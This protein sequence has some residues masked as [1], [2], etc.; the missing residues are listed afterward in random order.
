AMYQ[1]RR[2]G[3]DSDTFGWALERAL[4][5]FVAEAWRHPDEGIWEVRGQRQ[6]FTHSKV[7]AWVAVDRAV[8]SAEQYQLDAPVEEWKRLRQEIH[9]EVC[10]AGYNTEMNSFVQYYGSNELDASLLMIPLV[11]FLPPDDE[12][13]RGTVSA[14]ERGLMR[15]DFVQRYATRSGVD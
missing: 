4:V 2:A 15:D 13:V 9:E 7:M 10:R 6:H 8:K 5:N 3:L 14:I 12:R 1:A 11:G